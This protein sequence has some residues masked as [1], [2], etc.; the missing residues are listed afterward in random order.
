MPSP[1]PQPKGYPLVGNLFDID[2]QNPWGSFNKLAL[3]NK[4]REYHPSPDVP[5]SL[6][7]FLIVL[8]L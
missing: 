8:G 4:Y 6:S 1:I 5:P 3:K 7:S 2:S